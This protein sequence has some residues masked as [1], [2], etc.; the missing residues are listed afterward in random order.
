MKFILETLKALEKG[1]FEIEV[2]KIYGNNLDRLIRGLKDADKSIIYEIEEYTEYEYE[3]I[4][5]A[6]IE[7]RAF[8][9]MN[10]PRLKMIQKMIMLLGHPRIFNAVMKYGKIEVSYHDFQGNLHTVSDYNELDFI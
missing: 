5:P 10:Q 9:K 7:L 6:L 3:E 8:Y 2:A 4:L 1:E